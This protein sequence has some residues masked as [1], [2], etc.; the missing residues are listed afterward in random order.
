MNPGLVRTT[1]KE[2]LTPE[3]PRPSRPTRGRPVRQQMRA[4]GL[5]G[6]TRPRPRYG[7][8]ASTRR[9]GTRSPAGASER[10]RRHERQAH[11]GLPER[12]PG[13]RRGEVRTAARRADPPGASA[14]RPP[15]LLWYPSAA[16]RYHNNP[17]VWYPP[18]QARVL[19]PP[20]HLTGAPSRRV[21]VPG[22]LS[23]RGE[24]SSRS[25]SASPRA[26]NPAGSVSSR[27]RSGE[28]RA[29]WPL[30][31][32]SRRKCPRCGTRNV[33]GVRPGHPR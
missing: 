20:Q 11:I 2:K 13:R 9:A 23:A 10:I 14:G 16:G 25:A 26:A 6:M 33:L 19:R 31:I 15:G 3:T 5:P 7:R 32:P 29:G 18:T 24:P 17:P 12:R 4:L 8:P 22:A 27:R 1:G 21:A 28:P 30:R